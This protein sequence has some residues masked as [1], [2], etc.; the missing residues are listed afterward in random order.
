M[1]ISEA[2]ESIVNEIEP[3]C[4]FDSHFVIKQLIKRDS[5]SYLRFCSQYANSNETTLTAHQQ[6]GQEI[7]KFDNNLVKRQS[8]E[9]WSENIHGKASKCATWKRI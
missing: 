4:I 5:N 9:S 8:F 7:K 2:I 1:S 3:R 6:I